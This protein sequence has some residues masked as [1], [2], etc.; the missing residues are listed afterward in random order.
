MRKAALLVLFLA[1]ALPLAHAGESFPCGNRQDMVRTIFVQNRQAF[2]A[3][4]ITSRGLTL[5][6]FASP[7]DGFSILGVAKNGEACLL[8]AGGS[9]SFV[10]ERRL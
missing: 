5:E 2:I 10:A 8:L 3:T 1:T 4:A 9:W 6:V 7:Q